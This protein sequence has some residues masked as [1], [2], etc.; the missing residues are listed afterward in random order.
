MRQSLKAWALS[1]S[2]QTEQSCNTKDQVFAR[3]HGSN[4][5][6]KDDQG[7]RMRVHTAMWTG[8]VDSLYN[9]A[10]KPASKGG[11]DQMLDEAGQPRMGESTFGKMLPPEFRKLTNKHA[12]D[13]VCVTCQDANLCL[14]DLKGYNR[15]R[16][17]KMELQISILKAAIDN[18]SSR[19]RST[20]G[21]HM[22][23]KSKIASQLDIS[24]EET[25]Y[26]LINEE[27]ANNAYNPSSDSIFRSDSD[28]SIGRCFEVCRSS[29]I[30]A[31]S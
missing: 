31:L 12:Q 7:N 6:L 17:Q 14:L 2:N 24:I 27:I 5:I 23:I 28:C 13:C 18:L 8:T 29:S 3:D 25:D 26:F 15:R 22:E 30:T 10:T 19:R 20:A 1:K 9:E 11:W 21:E 16:V 4:K